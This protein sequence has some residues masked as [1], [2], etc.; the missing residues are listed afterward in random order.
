MTDHHFYPLTISNI[1]RETQDCVSVTLDIPAS[2]ND[3]FKYE[4][5][6]Y[7]TFKLTIDGEELRRSYSICSAPYQNKLT[8]AIKKVENGRFSTFA[9]DTLKVGDTLMVMPPLGNFLLKEQ[10]AGVAQYVFFASGSGITP[11]IAQIKHL[12]NTNQQTEIILF[13][14]NK[15]VDSIIFREEI[16]GLKNTYLQRL[17]VYYIFSKEKMGS[18]LFYGR[19]DSQKCGQFAKTIFRTELVAQYLLCGPAEM[20]FDIQTQLLTLGVESDKIRFELFNTDGIIKK[21]EVK[22]LDP[23]LNISSKISIKLDGDIFEFPLTYQGE[24]I[25]D[26]ALKNGADLPFA[27]KGGVCSTCKAKLVEGEID[28]D[29]NYALEP[30]ELAAGY[31]LTCQAHPRTEIVKVDFD[32]K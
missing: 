21:T 22:S 19:I 4:A 29:I 12:L 13:Y 10:T 30:D 20:I 24:S 5:G 3:I 15:N 16:E 9:N 11:I 27:C 8:V 18:P 31:I 32:Q 28:M 26:T 2:L 14:G 25:L 1:T 23:A 6:Q 17:A 7:V